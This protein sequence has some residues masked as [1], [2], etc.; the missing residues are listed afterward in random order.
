MRLLQLQRATVRFSPFRLAR[1]F[2]FLAGWNNRDATEHGTSVPCSFSFEQSYSRQD[3]RS[4]DYC[5]SFGYPK[6]AGP[7]AW[8]R[9]TEHCRVNGSLRLGSSFICS[10]ASKNNSLGSVLCL[11]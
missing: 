5:M 2:Y 9:G 7:S 8:P 3:S 6:A 10:S 11:G 1:R 4:T